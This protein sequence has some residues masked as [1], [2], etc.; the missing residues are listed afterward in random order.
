VRIPISWLGDWVDL[1]DDVTLE[2]LHAALVKVG[3]EEEDVHGFG[4]QGPVVVGRVLSFVDEPQSNGK[5]I[6]WVQVDVGEPEPRGIVCGAHN[7]EVGDLVPVSLPGAVLPG[8]FPITA[9][10]TYGHV[11]DGMIASERELGLGDEHS[12]IL[13]LHERGLVGEPGEDAIA[14]LGLDDAAV[15]INV[16][17]DR[18]YALSIRGLARE[19]SHS[20]GAAFRDPALEPVVAEAAGYSV[21]VDDSAPIRG[22]IGC[23]AF[24]ARVVRGV[25][26]TRPTPS[27]M[28]ARLKLAGIR[29]ISLPVDISNYVMIELG[30]PTHAY[31]LA[32]LAGGIVVRRAAAGETLETLDGQ[33]RSLDVEDLLITDDSGAIG[34]AGVMG[35]LA[36]EVSDATT[37]ILVEAAHF[38]P[39]TVARTARRHK[40]WSE[41]SKRFERGV[42][43]TL[44]PI[45]AQRVADLLVELAGGTIDPLGTVV[46]YLGE[47]IPIAFA[48]ADAGALIGVEYTDDEVRGTLELIGATVDA[49]V[50]RWTV[51]PPAWRPDLIDAPSL[52]EE[53]ARI[54]G[55]DR[56]PSELPVAP[57]GRGWTRSQQATRRLAQTLAA[58]GLTEVLAYPFQSAATVERFEPGA[59]AVELANALDP[60]SPFLRRSLLP[61]LLETARR[62][63]SRGLTDLGIFEIGT[64]FRPEAGVA[65]GTD[66]LPPGAVELAPD[67]LD[68]LTTGLPPQPR[69]VAVLL[70]GDV[71]PKQPGAAAVPAGLADALDAVADVGLALA[72]DIRPVTGSHPA[73]HPGR[74]AELR[75]GDV[76]VGVAGELLPSLARELDLPGVVAV[77]E[78]DVD[79]L[80]AL[81]ATEIAARPIGTLPA[82]TQDVSLVVPVETPAA[83]IRDAVIEGAG[84]LL[85]DARLVDDYRGPGVPDGTKSLTFAL[86]FRA[87]DRTLTAAEATEAKLAG[88]ALAASRLKATLRE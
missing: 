7:F 78:L 52:I 9:R 27:G 20:T 84:D 3:F 40:L 2:H 70:L 71:I 5:T 17:P 42:D 32:K 39:V 38:D 23:D 31:D 59:A 73:L 29:S 74:T 53:V 68:A 67:V 14:L 37:D 44:G 8:P 11:S 58:A 49:T 6:R 57:P 48:P 46:P 1:P 69:R 18:G 77:A 33:V 25:D 72:A 24:A 63:L 76:I 81:G 54:T 85:E 41:A 22:R 19:Y 10:K 56:I 65:Y 62:N 86:R 12:G 15:E 45:A 30:Q 61:G 79:A 34:L 87:A 82:A 66:E 51:T 75:I 26:A 47:P 50:D 83:D 88:V 35:G 60:Q 16:T 13:R 21:R 43:P 28:V 64:V 80:L 36:T 4:V 55:Y